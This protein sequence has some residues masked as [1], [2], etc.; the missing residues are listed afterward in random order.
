MKTPSVSILLPFRDSA[1][2]LAGAIQSI[3][4]QTFADWELL[5]VDDG[6]QDDSPAIARRCAAEDERLR[7]LYVNSG[8]IVKALRLASREARGRY[9]ARMDADDV[10]LP[11]RL[12]RQVRM[13]EEDP[14][15]GLV[16]TQVRMTGPRIGT[17]R[18]RYEDWMNALCDHDAMVRELF[19]ECPIA[20]PAF[21]MQRAAFERAGG[22]VDS[23]WAEDYDLVMRLWL[24]GT[25]FGKVNDILLEWRERPDRLSMRDPRYEPAQFRALKR[26]YL[27]ASYLRQPLARTFMQWGAGE[28]GKVWLREWTAPTPSAV[29]DINPR[30][31]GRTIH[32]IPVVSPDELPSPGRAFTVIAVG[33]PGARDEIR[34][35]LDPRGYVELEDYL[36]IA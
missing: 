33:A 5:L 9:F 17:G 28:V 20:H 27:A 25:R 10:S 1:D 18:K 19:V 21:L 16:G 35:W 2:T 3:R 29:V 24:G 14:R 8:G 12:E 36:F 4:T 34:Q 30:K 7:M 32:G 26:H 15:L 13:M 11:T 22:Y 23:G 31:I 6:S